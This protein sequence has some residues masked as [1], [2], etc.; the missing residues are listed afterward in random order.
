M[1]NLKKYWKNM[2]LKNNEDVKIPLKMG[3]RLISDTDE[4]DIF[5]VGFPKSGNTW[6]QHI[7]AHLIYGLNGNQ[8]RTLIDIIVP[9]IYYNRTYFRIKDVCFFKSHELP[10]PKYKN[11]IYIVRDGRDALVSY[12]N[13]HKNMGEEVSIEDFFLG[14]VNMIT[15]WENH[16]KSWVDNPYNSR[17]LYV[18]YEDLISNP[19]YEYKKISNFINAL[20]SD[21]NIINAIRETSFNS[22][23]QLEKN[24]LPWKEQKKKVNFKE[25]TSFIRKGNIGEYNG[26]VP[27]NLINSFNN[28][29]HEMLYYFNYNIF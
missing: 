18:R 20:D 3:E 25:N 11:V 7:I 5:I 24:D 27:K 23:K 6:M 14:K 9:D 17:I 22:M 2:F 1:N 4:K 15:S 12:Y 29:A 10:T 8:S 19:F 16:T 13:M 28:R 21:E 26:V